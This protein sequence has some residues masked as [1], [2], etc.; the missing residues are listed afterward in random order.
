MNFWR[1]DVPELA[2][3]GLAGCSLDVCKTGEGSGKGKKK[4]RRLVPSA[5]SQSLKIG[6]E[7]ELEF[8]KLK[9]PTVSVSGHGS[10]SNFI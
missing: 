8:L 5:F 4:S 6:G 10:T 1:T 2:E 3:C 7:T 9:G